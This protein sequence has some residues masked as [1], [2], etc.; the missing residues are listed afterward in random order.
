MRHRFVY[1]P[2]YYNEDTQFAELAVFMSYMFL[3]ISIFILFLILIVLYLFLTATTVQEK[4][5]YT[6]NLII[7]NCITIILL[8]TYMCIKRIINSRNEN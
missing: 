1:L 6:I 4:N 2:L 7:L 3:A 5:G 8:T